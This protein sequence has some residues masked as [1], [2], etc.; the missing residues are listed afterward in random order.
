MRCALEPLSVGYDWE[1]AVLKDT[2][3]NIDEKEADRLADELRV[4]IPWAAPGT[5]LEL[6]ESRLGPLSDFRELVERTERFDERLR[7]ALSARGW[8]LLRSGTRPI[9]REPIGAHIHV[10]TVRD[11]DAAVRVQNGAAA[12][13]APLVALAANSP[14][15][16]NRWGRYKSYRVASFAEFCSLPPMLASPGATQPGWGTDVCIKLP[17]GSTVELRACDGATSARLMCELVA[18]TAGIMHH[19]AEHGDG[20]PPGDEAYAELMLNRWRAAKH[21]LAAV[22]RVDGEDVPAQSVL[23]DMLD[24]AQDGMTRI[25]ASPDD[26]ALIRKMIAKR[27]TQ[28]D[29]QRAVFESEG[30]DPHRFTRALANIQRDGRAFERYLRT[31]PALDAA[32]PDDPAA[33]IASDIGV[34]TPYTLLLRGA[35]PAPAELDRVLADLVRTG[36]VIEGRTRLGVRTFTRA[37]LV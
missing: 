31:A 22:F 5:D 34:E 11:W 18:L 29:F 2:G 16:R 4:R 15:Y 10:G 28:A 32:P 9:E 24:L 33:D 12:Y 20:R 25:G 13:V 1:M 7:K 17:S 21:G 19:A 23:T 27:Q 30:R 8:S 14:V 3:E 36:K 37:D 6:I 26:L 35:Q